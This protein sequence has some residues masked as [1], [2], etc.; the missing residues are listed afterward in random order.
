MRRT[1]GYGALAAA[2]LLAIAGC[3]SGTSS[4]E[5]GA[6]ANAAGGEPDTNAPA[7]GGFSNSVAAGSDGAMDAERN[8]VGAAPQDSSSGASGNS[9]DNAPLV[10]GAA[11]NGGPAS[12]DLGPDPTGATSPANSS[13]SGNR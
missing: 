1:M 4:E 7:G 10:G 13:G 12:A 11:G 3:S 9:A 5:S 2:G 6:T 8:V